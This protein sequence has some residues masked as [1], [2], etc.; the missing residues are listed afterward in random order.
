MEA[1][2]LDENLEARV[3]QSA[4]ESNPDMEEQQAELWDHNFIYDSIYL[5]LL[6]FIEE[7]FTR[8]KWKCTKVCKKK[9]W[10]PSRETWM[11]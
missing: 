1:L 8:I 9:L 11:I 2:K 3:K 7:N 5:T 10:F 6:A 4:I